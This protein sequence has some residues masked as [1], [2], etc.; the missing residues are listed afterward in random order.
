MTISLYLYRTSIACVQKKLHKK[1][2][3]P[4]KTTKNSPDPPL[5]T[6]FFPSHGL[7][8]LYAEG[9]PPFMKIISLRQCPDELGR[10]VDFF[11]RH[12]GMRELYRNCMTASLSTKSPLPQWYLLVEEDDRIVGGA[13]LV[14]NDF[15]SRMD[16]W[17]WLCALFVEDEF[18][19]H[20]Y[21]A[22][23]IQYLKQE[24]CRLGFL[25]L[26]LATDSTGYYEKYGS[27]YAPPSERYQ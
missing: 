13:G 20:A 27:Q 24:S 2:R 4:E 15:I 3:I 22:L 14:S 6:C 21:G 23:L 25:K 16:L 18:R 5:R 11:S 9:G 1:T 10:F 8:F 7:L 26:Y 12:W 19:G 17:P